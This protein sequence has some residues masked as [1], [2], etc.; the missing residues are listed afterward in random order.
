MPLR[1]LNLLAQQGALIEHA[2][3]ELAKGEYHFALHAT[4]DRAAVICEKI[5]AMVL[6]HSVELS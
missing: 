1:V 6:V 2:E 5:R 3:L 4:T